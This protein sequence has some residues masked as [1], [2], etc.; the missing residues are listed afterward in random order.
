MQYE[1]HPNQALNCNIFRIPVYPLSNR[2]H[3]AHHSHNG[4][5]IRSFAPVVSVVGGP[6][7]QSLQT[8][9]GI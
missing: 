2:S 5:E 8:S 1:K 3:E 4:F 6:P 9:R 7:G